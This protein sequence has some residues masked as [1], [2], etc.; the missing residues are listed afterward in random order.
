MRLGAA[1]LFAARLACIHTLSIPSVRAHPLASEPYAP[2]LAMHLPVPRCPPTRCALRKPCRSRGRAAAPIVC[3]SEVAAANAG[4]AGGGC[5][6]RFVT[7][8]S[9]AHAPFVAIYS[10]Y[11]F[12]FANITAAVGDH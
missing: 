2:C 1:V 9:V 7:Y 10:L 5:F 6:P 3:V 12:M 4:F 8:C 11:L